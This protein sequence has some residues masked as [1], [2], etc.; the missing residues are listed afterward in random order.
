M[1]NT[2]IRNSF[3]TATISALGAELQSLMDNT[4]CNYLWTGD[5]KYWNE[6][7]PI[8]FPIVGKLKGNK[9]IFEGKTYSMVQHGF[10][11]AMTF[12]VAEQGESYVN[13]VLSSDELTLSMYPFR[14]L[15]YVNYVLT[16]P[17]LS[18]MYRVINQDHKTMYFSIGA[19]PGFICPFH[20]T[21]EIESYSIVFDAFENAQ[22]LLENNDLLLTHKKFP[23]K[24]EAMVLNPHTFENGTLIFSNLKSKH[25]YLQ[26]THY[27]KKIRLDF[28]GFPYLGLWSKADIKAPF[29]V[30]QPLYGHSDY[31]DASYDL[32]EKENMITL[33]PME[34]FSCV[35]S[36]SIL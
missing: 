11:R 26:A 22:F 17:T 12:K 4:G 15:L 34:T 32:S 23:F 1:L 31:N 36:I 27:D 35:H 29:V 2:T 7:A 16:G 18:V 9:Y 10:A 6:R 25:V 30:I 21:N 14:F 19:H 24:G 13:Y 28:E 3:L 33:K 20:E 5:A 8:L